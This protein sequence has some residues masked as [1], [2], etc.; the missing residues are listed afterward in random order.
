MHGYLVAFLGIWPS[1]RHSECCACWIESSSENG[2]RLPR[3]PQRL[4]YTDVHE[5]ICT[6][7][8]QLSAFVSHKL[9]KQSAGKDSQASLNAF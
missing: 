3:R 9:L 8:I 5:L 1:F 7:N 2:V 6:G 4:I